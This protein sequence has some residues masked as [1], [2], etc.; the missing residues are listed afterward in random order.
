[1]AHTH[2]QITPL[3]GL[4]GHAS[5]LESGRGTSFPH[6]LWETLWISTGKEFTQLWESGVLR[7]V[8]IVSKLF[9]KLSTE[10]S[11]ALAESCSTIHRLYY[12]NYFN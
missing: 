10:F 7:V 8:H 1:M 6:D 11:T 9:T 2:P 4:F 3:L 12:Y 5:Y